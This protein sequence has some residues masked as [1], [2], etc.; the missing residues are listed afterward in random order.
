MRFELISFPFALLLK[1][2][3]TTVILIILSILKLTSL[4]WNYK[5]FYFVKTSL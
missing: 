1:G 3:N 2:P 4:V 5:A